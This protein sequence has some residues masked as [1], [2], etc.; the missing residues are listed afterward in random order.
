MA[1]KTCWIYYKQARQRRD[2]RDRTLPVHCAETTSEIRRHLNKTEK[3]LRAD[4]AAVIA[5]LLVEHVHQHQHV[6][7]HPQ[8]VPHHRGEK[9]VVARDPKHH[10]EEEPEAALAKV[11]PEEH[12]GPILVASNISIANQLE[13]QELPGWIKVTNSN[14]ASSLL[15]N[16]IRT[17]ITVR[18]VTSSHITGTTSATLPRSTC[19]A[20]SCIMSVGIETQTAHG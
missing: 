13:V 5:L 19:P 16:P 4:N 8:V 11:T 9:T 20:I 12:A 6:H 7:Q 2:E 15:A 1:R 18:D 14:T 3:G 10:M 17:D